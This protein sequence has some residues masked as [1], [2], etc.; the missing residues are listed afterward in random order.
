[1]PARAYD[2]DYLDLTTA[3]D[4]VP[5]FIGNNSI[6]HNPDRPRHGEPKDLAK[7]HLRDAGVMLGSPN[8][9]AR[10]LYW[11]ALNEI[12]EKGAAAIRRQDRIADVRG[13]LRTESRSAASVNPMTDNQTD[14]LIAFSH[15]ESMVS[16]Y[17]NDAARSN[18]AINPD[19]MLENLRTQSL[20]QATGLGGERRATIAS[21]VERAGGDTTPFFDRSAE[22]LQA[23]YDQSVRVIY[24]ET[25]KVTDVLA[26]SYA[27]AGREA[28]AA[29]LNRLSAADPTLLNDAERKRL[30]TAEAELEAL[31]SEQLTEAERARL[32]MQILRSGTQI[33]YAPQRAS[34]DR[35][36]E[37]VVTRAA[38][39]A[40][41][42][43]YEFTPAERRIIQIQ[44]DAAASGHPVEM[45]EAD[46]NRT[47]RFASVMDQADAI[48][49]SP[50]FARYKAVAGAMITGAT[51]RER[52]DQIA[53]A[54]SGGNATRIRG[55]DQLD[56]VA[57]SVAEATVIARLL[58]FVAINRGDQVPSRETVGALLEGVQTSLSH[59][60][61]MRMPTRTLLETPRYIITEGP[62]GKT[63]DRIHP[64]WEAFRAGKN[65]ADKALNAFGQTPRDQ[66]GVSLREAPPTL[67]YLAVT[68]HAF[69]GP[70]ASRLQM[71]AIGLE[72]A[73]YFK[74]PD[75]ITSTVKDVAAQNAK[76]KTS[77]RTPLI[78]IADPNAGNKND[79]SRSA[80]AILAAAQAAGMSV[81]RVEASLDPK[82]MLRLNAGGALVDD[83]SNRGW[84]AYNIVAENGEKIPLYS[85]RAKYLAQQNK[86]GSLLLIDPKPPSS[87][88]NK[89]EAAKSP[90]QKQRLTDQYDRMKRTISW[91]AL[92]SLTTQTTVFGLTDKD[93]NACQAA[94]RSMD[95]DKK[96]TVYDEDGKPMAADRAYALAR[97]GAPKARDSVVQG[98]ARSIYL[99]R[100]V[101]QQMTKPAASQLGRLALAFLTSTKDAERIAGAAK[102][103]RVKHGLETPISIRDLVDAATLTGDK[104]RALDPQKAAV[105]KDLVAAI[106]SDRAAFQ[107]AK[108]VGFGMQFAIDS[109][110]QMSPTISVGGTNKANPAYLGENS[111][112]A[113]TGPLVEA[114]NQPLAIQGHPDLI[115]KLGRPDVAIIGSSTSTPDDKMAKVIADLVQTAGEK[116]QTISTTNDPTG[117]VVI[118]AARNSGAKVMV[119]VDP[120]AKT[121]LSPESRAALTEMISQ[122][123]A[124]EVAPSLPP[125]VD[126]GQ[127]GAERDGELVNRWNALNARF[128]A[129]ATQSRIRALETAVAPAKAV[130][131]AAARANDPALFVAARAGQDKR[132]EPIGGKPVAVIAASPTRM[133]RS[134]QQGGAELLKPNRSVMIDTGHST[135]MTNASVGVRFVDSK[136]GETDR[137]GRE[138]GQEFFG[139]QSRAVASW[140]NPAKPIADAKQATAFLAAVAEGKAE[141][142]H[143]K[144]RQGMT[145]ADVAFLTGA[146]R[147]PTENEKKFAALESNE[148]PTLIE[149][150]STIHQALSKHFRVTTRGAGREAFA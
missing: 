112:I 1:M 129:T 3:A 56:I 44:I 102:A 48:I 12:V 49:Q 97:I 80:A 7:D 57:S 45:S 14:A 136:T 29:E 59:S 137:S 100:D 66:N 2:F 40:L 72:G 139:M 91:Q 60:Q 101:E 111:T 41:I 51:A 107:S 47:K 32:T 106:G 93:F 21:L 15:V 142:M 117:E 104:Y 67:G 125:M 138:R 89:I 11:S 81:L 42:N 147:H 16:S 43:D 99:G 130:A 148:P 145:A 135:I 146:V 38:T 37:F 17:L 141:P 115:E 53:Q 64:Y 10:A 84:L 124:I 62:N 70:N 95:F 28:V 65:R 121:G 13:A 94:R 34:S 83:K 110:L 120:S 52:A 131:V 126:L 58:D 31:D 23:L 79:H 74:H 24:N 98:S 35:D 18:N 105:M 20:D 82:D 30:E 134:D 61:T 116:G 143:G 33:E 92:Q 140:V 46:R 90:D 88:L 128:A 127:R 39:A 68:A 132:I 25:A 103:L 71:D 108:K 85:S 123:R 19:A 114:A 77:D 54:L 96:T 122:G 150:A 6:L 55:L 118:N 9:E 8:N 63:A 87:L 26:F 5:V 113:I 75:V 149:R 27:A 119:V 133:L 86:A 144:F 76:V 73:K 69:L 36:V 50:E 78:A 109:V 22:E 4:R